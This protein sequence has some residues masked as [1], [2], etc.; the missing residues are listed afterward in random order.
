MMKFVYLL[1]A[2]AGL[3]A[4]GTMEQQQ[5]SDINA[6]PKEYVTGSMLPQRN[7]NAKVEKL[8]KEQVEEFQR[9]SN[10]ALGTVGK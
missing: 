5:G 3:S 1:L 7:S 8:S 2:V 9:T 6:E 4:C 10:N